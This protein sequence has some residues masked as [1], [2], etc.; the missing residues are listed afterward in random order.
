MAF[1]VRLSLHRSQLPPL[2][3]LQTTPRLARTMSMNKGTSSQSDISKMA[4]H[5][6]DGSFKRA[7]S[8]FRNVIEKGGK[9]EAEKGKLY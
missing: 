8:S 5:D 4:A 2:T 7:A 6:A 1:F 9:F 3:F